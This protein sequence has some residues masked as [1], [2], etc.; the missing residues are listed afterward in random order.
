MLMKLSRENGFY[1][2]SVNGSHPGKITMAVGVK[3]VL[4][5]SIPKA[6][7]NLYKISHT[8]ILGEPFQRE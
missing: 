4:H 1:C 3:A 6:T 7:E 5:T 2:E 8:D